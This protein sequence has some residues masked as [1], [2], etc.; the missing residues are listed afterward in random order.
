M[1]VYEFI[2]SKFTCKLIVSLE[3]EPCIEYIIIIPIYC[4][5]VRIIGVKKIYVYKRT[6]VNDVYG[7]ERITQ[8]GTGFEIKNTY[9]EDGKDITVKSSIINCSEHEVITID[10]DNRLIASSKTPMRIIGDDFNWEWIYFVPDENYITIC[11]NCTVTFEWVE[12]IKI[13]HI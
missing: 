6:I 8:I 7:W 11:G 9:Y 12:P 1:D 4:R 5:I 3:M 13:G 10:G 2:F